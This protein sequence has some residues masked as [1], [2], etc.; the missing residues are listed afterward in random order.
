MTE[1]GIN[2]SHK[3]T[4]LYCVSIEP[5]EWKVL[6]CPRDAWLP[7]CAGLRTELGHVFLGGIPESL[8]PSLPGP[9]GE[10]HAFLCSRLITQWPDEWGLCSCA[11]ALPSPAIQRSGQIPVNPLPTHSDSSSR[12]VFETGTSPYMGLVYV[13]TLHKQQQFNNISP[14]INVWT[15]SL[16]WGFLLFID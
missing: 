12:L 11:P 9:P 10:Q 14:W 8:P 13:P 16:L 7:P 1:L 3:A 5:N 4:L 6:C 2:P 15:S